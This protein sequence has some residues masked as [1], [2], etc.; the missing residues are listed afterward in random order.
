[1]IHMMHT[2]EAAHGRIDRVLG[3]LSSHSPSC[4]GLWESPRISF[5][6]TDPG[7]LLMGIFKGSSALFLH[8]LTYLW[9]SQELRFSFIIQITREKKTQLVEISQTNFHDEN[10]LMLETEKIA[11]KD[12]IIS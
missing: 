6:L 1:M 8:P 3:P 9:P 7:A 12:L 10:E 4:C 2:R 11:M 5:P